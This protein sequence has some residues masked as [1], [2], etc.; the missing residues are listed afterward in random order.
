MTLIPDL[1]RDL[2]DAAGRV[3]GGWRRFGPPLR[4][5]MAGAAAAALICAM[6]LIVGRD[7]SDPARSSRNTATPP[8]RTAPAPPTH[9]RPLPGTF[10]DP[11]RFE[12]EGVRYSLVGF[13]S[14]GDVICMRLV[15]GVPGRP[16]ASSTCAGERLLRR[17]L[18]DHPVR[19]VGTGG[20]ESTFVSG[21]ARV[22]VTTLELI[23][24]R[25]PSRAV[26]SAPW[27]PKGWRGKPIRFFEVAIDLPPGAA[28]NIPQ[29][30]RIRLQ[31]RL[32]SGETVD[33]IP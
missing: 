28:R 6:V 20:A 27:R 26:L 12:F 25:Y 30:S 9:M 2:V 21:F 16:L 24:P 3:H 29:L 1:E 8:N 23:S 10:S 7:G 4:L 18:P 11:V 33:S 17:E 14:R 5:A 31:G 32:A 15:E 19:I 13:R 22:D